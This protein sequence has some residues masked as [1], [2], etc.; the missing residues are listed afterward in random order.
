MLQEN[1]ENHAAAFIA[2][3][4][5]NQRQLKVVSKKAAKLGMRAGEVLA[6]E[7]VTLAYALADAL[8][9]AESELE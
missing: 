1:I 3:R 6:G 5:G 8:A 9:K 7:C 2:A 4:L